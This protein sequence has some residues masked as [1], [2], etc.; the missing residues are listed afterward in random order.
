MYFL[1]ALGLTI[2]SLMLFLILKNKK[3]WH[4][5]ILAI[6][7]GASTLMWLIDCFASLIKGEHFLSFEIPTD[8]YISIWTL[9]GGFIL[10]GIITIIINKK[11]KGNN[12]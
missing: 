6:I 9:V 7:Y 1:V 2:L 12:N 10:W 3:R 4:L 8:I 5:E 11:D